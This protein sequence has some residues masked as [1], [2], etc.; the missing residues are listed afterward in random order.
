VQ[1]KECIENSKSSLANCY[2]KITLTAAIYVTNQE[3]KKYLDLT[4]KSVVSQKHSIVWVPCENYVTPGLAPLTYTFNQP[5]DEIK[6]LHPT[7]QQNVSQAWNR[8]IEEGGKAGCK[9]ILVINTDVVFKS[10]AVDRL[11]DFAESRTDAVLWTMTEC[12]ELASLESC[13]EDEGFVE[14]PN[15]SCFMVK[16]DFFEH[17]GK[18]DENFS[19]AYC[20]DSDMHARIILAGLKAYAYGG[21]KFYHY[22]SQTIKSDQDLQSKNARTYPKCQLYFLEKWGHSM[23]NDVE[24]MRGAYFG[25]PYGE[26]DKPLSYWRQASS[27]GLFRKLGNLLSLSARYRLVRVLNW[28]KRTRSRAKH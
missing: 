13:P 25:H 23:V 5:I 21:A 6:V 10:N 16:S 20:E 8:G 1:L 3:H 12:K 9:Y 15:F 18:F 17:V 28:I 7:G 24:E 26:E 4:T 11:I 2:M 14:N 27:V 22:G 19:P